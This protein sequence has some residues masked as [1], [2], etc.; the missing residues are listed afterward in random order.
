MQ[1]TH[2]LVSRVYRGPGPIQGITDL[3]CPLT[4]NFFVKAISSHCLPNCGRGLEKGVREFLV[5]SA[6][7]AFAFRDRVPNKARLV[8]L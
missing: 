5:Q 1:F 7:V 2:A 3:A 6:A 4:Y 8:A